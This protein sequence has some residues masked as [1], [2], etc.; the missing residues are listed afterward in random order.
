M[1]S[2]RAAMT[3]FNIAPRFHPKY[4][5]WGTTPI[6]TETDMP[7]ETRCLAL[8]Q[9]GRRLV[10]F[11]HDLCG[12]SVADTDALRKEI[13]EEIGLDPQQVIW[14][15]SQ[16]HSSP[17]LP[18]TSMPGGSCI[19]VRGEFDVEF[20]NPERTRFVR[21]CIEA[22]RE[23]IDSLKSAKVW[24]GRGYCD[25]ISYNSRF[26]MPTGGVKFSRNY[27]EAV[28]SGRYFDPT[29]RLVRFDDAGGNA[30]GAIFN[31]GCHPATM[32]N[33]KYVSPDYV[34]TARRIIQEEIGAPAM[35]VQGFCG[36]VHNYYMFTGPDQAT[37]LGGR[38]GKAAVEGLR[39]LVPLRCEP[40][41]HVWKTVKLDCRPMYTRAELQQEIA[42]RNAY[43]DELRQYPGA[44]WVCGTDLPVF[45]DAQQKAAT[46]KVQMDYLEQGLLML[47]IGE[48]PQQLLSITLGA[49]RIGD[50][51]AILSPGENF[52]ETGRDIRNRSPF[53]HTL[54]C[55]DTNGLF[56]YIGNDEEIDR[57]GYETDTSWK[58]L[59]I[60]GFRLALAKGSAGRM[61]STA[62]DLLKQVHASSKKM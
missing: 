49:I 48:S 59:H 58:V 11:A 44:V 23:A 24:S 30:I 26:P 20:C 37:L 55:G 17:T 39:A 4:G 60:D 54:T 1:N 56:G 40:L 13:A 27:A 46:V 7:I 42:A 34:G 45:F 47:D 19:T 6:M 52:A 16:T 5:A 9:Q 33:D 41:Q 38:L 2:L 62:L 12:N 50:L 32:V 14:S 36:N 8:D 53:P 3:G 18:G 15:T 57:G 22:G 51:Y 29:V 10:W 43:L 21:R 25:N 35:F 28:Q 61:I 31:F